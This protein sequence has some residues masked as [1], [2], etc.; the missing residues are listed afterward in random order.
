MKITSEGQVTIPLEI[1]DKLGVIPNTEVEFE[2]IGDALYLKKAK[3][4][5]TAGER[6]IEMMR[7]KARVK[8]TTDEIMSL[9]RQD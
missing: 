7:G 4:N 1:R 5:P 3:L 9:T 6:L 8:M 2:V